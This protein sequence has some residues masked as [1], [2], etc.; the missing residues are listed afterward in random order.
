VGS[1]SHGLG[2]FLF[3]EFPKGSGI[4]SRE[5]R[6]RREK[7]GFFPE[8]LKG[9]GIHLCTLFVLEP[10]IG[11]WGDLC[12]ALVRPLWAQVYTG[13]F[14]GPLFFAVGHSVTFFSGGCLVLPR[15]VSG[16]TLPYNWGG[17]PYFTTCFRG[18]WL[19]FKHWDHQG[20]PRGVPKSLEFFILRQIF[21]SLGDFVRTPWGSIFFEP[22]YIEGGFF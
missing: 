3:G 13:F 19:F 10:L 6:H 18:E 21:F 12:L 17:H 4:F 15:I 11:N 2:P 14:P 20:V 16:A 9:Y 5:K 7:N 1:E 8:R 22:I